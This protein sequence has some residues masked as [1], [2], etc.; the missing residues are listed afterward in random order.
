MVRR[1]RAWWDERLPIH[2]TGGFYDVDGYVADPNRTS[3]PDFVVA[4]VGDVVGLDLVHLQ[5]HFGL[6]I[7][8]WA[9]RGARVVGVDFSAPAVEAA[10]T[11]AART[12]IE[13][14]FV[15][16]NVYE[17][18]NA[19][20]GRKFDVVYTGLGAINWL[21]DIDRWPAVV[22]SLLTPGRSLVRGGVSPVH[23]CIR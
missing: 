18:Q 22:A 8:S 15:V 17:A 12:E 3:L 20:G 4:E 14:E 6:E 7:L 11:L 23:P 16:A 9:R 10:R 19:L 5:C 2:A 1:D 13:A 21:P